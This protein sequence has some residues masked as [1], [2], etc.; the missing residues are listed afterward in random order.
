MNSLT[1][2]LDLGGTLLDTPDIFEIV[3]RRLVDKWPD[4]RTSKLVLETY[5]GM[6][7]SIRH[8]ED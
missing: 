3:T 8:K 4:M 1:V 5:E 6:I 2:F 7:S